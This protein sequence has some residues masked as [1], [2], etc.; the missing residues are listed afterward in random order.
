MDIPRKNVARR[1]RIQRGILLVLGLVAVVMITLGLSRLEPA[2]PA[3]DLIPQSGTGDSARPRLLVAED[4]A[5]IR[6]LLKAMLRQGGVDS[7]CALNGREAVELWTRGEYDLVVMDIESMGKSQ[8]IAGLEV[9]FEIIFIHG[10]LNL[11]RNQNHDQVR[12]IGRFMVEQHLESVFFSS[13]FEFIVACIQSH[14]DLDTAVLQVQRMGM[15]LTAVSDN[16]NFFA[17]DKTDIRIF[18]IIHFH[19]CSSDCYLSY[20]IVKVIK[21]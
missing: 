2:A 17:L 13:F 1:R 4:D 7:D 15:P 19:S 18:I 6:E 9:S 10:K 11:I 3:V 8:D 5:N 12:P 14:H 16:R 20:Y 21:P